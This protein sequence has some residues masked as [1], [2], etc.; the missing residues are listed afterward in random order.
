MLFIEFR[1]KIYCKCI[2][3]IEDWHV[4]AKKCANINRGFSQRKIAAKHRV[5]YF[6][7]SSHL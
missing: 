2:K 1:S 5:S 4:L 3:K 6:L 7:L